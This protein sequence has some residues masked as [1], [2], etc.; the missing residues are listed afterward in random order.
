MQDIS[1]WADVPFQQMR[2]EMLDEEGSIAFRGDILRTSG[3]G[4]VFYGDYQI[5]ADSIQ[6]DKQTGNVHL[7][8]DVVITKPEHRM[9]TLYLDYNIKTKLGQT[10]HIHGE[11]IKHDPETILKALSQK[12]NIEHN[13][14]FTAKG[15]EM[16]Q[17]EFGRP[18]MILIQPTFSD[19]NLPRP[20]HDLTAS[21]AEF[22]SA[23]K[24]EMWNMR[25]RIMRVP[26]FYFPYYL[27]DLQYDWPWTQWEIGSKADW[28]RY[29]T[30]KTL[31][32]PKKTKE[33]L[34]VGLDY[35][36]RR[37]LAYKLNWNGS[38]PQDLMRAQLH[39]YDEKWESENDKKT[40]IEQNRVRMGFYKRKKIAENLEF[41]A[42]AHYLTPTK[43]YFWVN[44][45]QSTISPNKLVAPAGGGVQEREGLL[46]EYYEDEYK[47]GKILENILALDYH[48]GKTFLTLSMLRPVDEEV[49]NSKVKNIELRGRNL[50]QSIKSSSFF[51]SNSFGIGHMGQRYGRELS[52]DDRVSLFGQEHVKDFVT[53]RLDLEQKVEKGFIFGPYL[54]I[55]PYIG[56]RSVIYEKSLKFEKKGLDFFQVDHENDL[57]SWAGQHRMTAGTV[58][59]NV[60]T[61]Y[62]K[63]GRREYK[64]QIKPSISFDYLAPSGFSNLQVPGKVDAIDSRSDARL[65]TVYRLDNDIYLR[66]K[67]HETRTLYSS[68]IRYTFL[69]KAEDNFRA[70]GQE[71]KND[72]NLEFNQ[73][74]FPFEEFR[75][76]SDIRVN[77]FQSRV[78]NM[79]YGIGYSKQRFE[80]NWDYIYRKELTNQEDSSKRHDVNLKILTYKADFKMNFSYDGDPISPKH[81]RKGLYKHGFKHIDLT[82][83]K[84]FHCMRGEVQ[85]QYDFEST[86]STLV[87]KFGPQIFGEQLPNYRHPFEE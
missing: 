48:R 67:N 66:K 70:Y 60:V 69:D 1:I 44:G 85:F 62:L 80:F 7:F 17:N 20:H 2:L 11:I 29:A 16:K 3:R 33:N 39:F 64:H 28:G 27:K 56:Q 57:N 71:L 14:F 23:E 75:L 6:F 81:Q 59:S 24:I 77:T 84:L 87:F 61:G 83:G 74:Y 53:T 72:T 13:Y 31:A 42:E 19:C 25:L 79:R 10:G 51:Y 45:N 68:F 63:L 73:S 49:R 47:R 86:G 50:P 26:Y 32:F 43:K 5:S 15:A 35:R 41:T 46:Q 8:G 30:V 12:Q 22:S 52:V 58:F 54:N 40:N 55:N 65:K 37:G 82:L 21:S 76:S 9:K 36:E 38:K 18:R 78:S 34:K 4:R